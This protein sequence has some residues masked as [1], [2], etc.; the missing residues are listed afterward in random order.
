MKKDPAVVLLFDSNHGTY[1]PKNFVDDETL[2]E[3]FGLTEQNKDHWGSCLDMEN[4]FYWDSWNW[5]LDNAKHESELGNYFITQTE[6]GDVWALDE[7]RM[8]REE[9]INFDLIDED[10]EDS[11]S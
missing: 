6:H 8:T 11:D 1:I 7:S 4:E 2:R 9:K 10:D 3:N 5:I